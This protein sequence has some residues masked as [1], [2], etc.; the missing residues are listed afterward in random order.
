MFSYPSVFCS[1]VNHAIE[2]SCYSKEQRYAVAKL[3]DATCTDKMPKLAQEFYNF[4]SLLSSK[5]HQRI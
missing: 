5:D 1:I 2:L 4:T 3:F